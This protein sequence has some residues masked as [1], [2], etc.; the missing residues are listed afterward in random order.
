MLPVLAQ[1]ARV[2]LVMR[3]C[4]NAAVMPLS[5]KLPRRVHPFVLQEQLAGLEAGVGRDRVGTLAERL[6]LA[7]RQDAVVGREG[8]EFAEPPDAGE[9]ER[10][11]AVRPTCSRSAPAT[12]GRAAGPSRRPRRAGRRTSGTGTR[13]PPGRR[14]PGKSGSMQRWNARSDMR[15]VVAEMIGLIG[16]V[17]RITGLRA[18]ERLPMC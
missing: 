6:P 11:G 17:R 1:A 4:V 10:V 8:E 3:A 2:A 15:D 13:C 18:A 7:D 12:S 16:D 5:L 9:I 14:S